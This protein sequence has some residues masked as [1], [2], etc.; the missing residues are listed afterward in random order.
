MITI[1]NITEAYTVL[2]K[3]KLDDDWQRRCSTKYQAYLFTCGLT[4]VIPTTKNMSTEK[5]IMP[6]PSKMA[7]SSPMLAT[8]FWLR[9]RCS[10]APSTL[11]SPSFSWDVTLWTSSLCLT[12]TRKTTRG[13]QGLHSESAKVDSLAIVGICRR[14]Q[15]T[16]E[17]TRLVKMEG[18]NLLHPF[19]RVI[20]NSICP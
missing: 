13:R 16:G 12:H 3:Y 1:N 4:V 9:T 7:R 19:Q 5:A 18:L 6:K 14:L 20:S 15:P 17:N 2:L 10:P 11:L 8:N